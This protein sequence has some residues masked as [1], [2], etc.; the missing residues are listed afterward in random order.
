MK[1]NF[2]LLMT[3]LLAFAVVAAGCA[4]KLESGQTANS[5]KTDAQSSNS[6]TPSG[7]GEIPIGMGISLT[8]GTA[9]FGEGVKRGVELAIEDFNAAGGYNGQKA[10]LVMYDDEAKPE[11]SVEV[12]QKLIN[13]DKVVALVG[14]ANS[15]NA[16][17]HGKIVQE[18]KIAEIVPVATG[19]K[20][21]K[22]FA[23]QDKNYIFRVSPLDSVQVSTILEELVTKKGLKKIGLIHDTEGYGQ[24]GREDVVKQMKEKYSMEPAVISAFDPKELNLEQAVRDMK[25]TGVEA[26]L[27]YGLAPQCAKL[28]EARNKEGLNVPIYATWAMGD[29]TVKKLVG[30]L[31]NENVFFVQSFTID[32]SDK[33]K[34]FHERVVAKYK[35]DVFP[36]ASAQ[37]YDSAKL[38]LE[39]IKK[40]GP[41]GQKIRDQ[42]ESFQDFEGVTAIG[43][44][45][46]AK[47]NHEAFGPKDMSIATYKN[48]EVASVK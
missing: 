35:D 17:A 4:P 42:I 31:V 38:I 5:G 21:T 1:R 19:S 46:F 18:A 7:G 32:Q 13:Q 16:M 23:D 29:P 43:K 26:V 45:P 6:G 2:F 15:G 9:L 30:D 22:Q 28:L 10:K 11:K 12:I 8:G 24:G 40:V 14:P 39:A 34:A 20:I 3:F 37:G 36:I 33:A 27:F 41:D 25:K 47:D 48:G 44:T